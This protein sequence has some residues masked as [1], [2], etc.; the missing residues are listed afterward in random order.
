M[1]FDP[2]IFVNQIQTKS[3]NEILDQ[4]EVDLSHL[5]QGNEDS[6]YKMLLKMDYAFQTIEENSRKS[7]P[8]RAETA[9]FE[10][11]LKGIQKNSAGFLRDIG[12]GEK[13]EQLRK[14]SAP[15]KEQGWWFLDDYRRQV[16]KKMIQ[17]IAISG[18]VILVVLLVLSLVYRFYLMP[19]P[20]VSG[21][22][23]HQMNAEQLLGQKDY[24]KAL[25]ETNLALSFSPDDSTLLVMR[26]VLEQKLGMTEVSGAD[27]AAAEE[28]AGTHEKF[29]LTRAQIYIEANDANSAIAD[30]QAA[31]QVN[32][33]SAEGYFF[34]GHAFELLQNNQQAIQAYSKASE[35]AEAQGKTELNGTI[36]VTM[37][38]LMQSIS[39]D[40]TPSSSITPTVNK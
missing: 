1:P 30:A 22:Y 36:R 38:L 37:A 35:L 26:G 7:M 6:A 2:T 14:L 17:S 24:A 27:F 34:L 15:H 40:T 23:T 29:L 3:L 31:I 21:L 11:L 20:K 28:K 12:G 33:N 25:S 5:G 19:D 18:G 8:N 32:P 9:Q 39:Y 16:Q 13:L 10:Y 4:L